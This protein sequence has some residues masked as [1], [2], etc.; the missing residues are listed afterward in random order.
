MAFYRVGEAFLAKVF[1]DEVEK[2]DREP[3]VGS[4]D[5]VLYYCDHGKRPARALELAEAEAR[6]RKDV[7]TCDA[8]AWALFRNGKVLEAER[9]VAD[10]LRLGTKDVLLLYHAG[11]IAR[12]AGKTEAA[13]DLLRRALAANPHFSEAH[14]REANRLLNDK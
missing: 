3:L 5:L 8:L 7:Y 2:A 6:S 14:A 11:V 13:R 4:R 10:A 1:F 9:A 12:A